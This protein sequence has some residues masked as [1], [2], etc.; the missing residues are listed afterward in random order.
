M[1]PNGY[2]QYRGRKTWLNYLLSVLVVLLAL[3]L[4]VSLAAL[5]LFPDRVRGWIGLPSAAPSPI[6][7]D[8]LSD[9]LVVE[10]AA[11]SS[12]PA[13]TPSPAASM[14]PRR[15]AP[16]GLVSVSAE[17]LLDGSARSSLKSS[18]G[19]VLS[20]KTAAGQWLEEAFSAANAE[21]P[22]VAAYLS[23]FA[24][25]AAAASHPDWALK[26]AAGDAYAD[27]RGISWLD[28]ANADVQADLIDRCKTLAGQGFDEI[29]LG[30]CAYPS[31]DLARSSELTTFC[32]ALKSALDEL[33]YEGRLSIVS[34]KDVFEASADAVTGQTLSAV[35]ECFERVYLSGA[36]RWK[37]GTNVYRLLQNAGFEGTAGDIVTLVS[38]P[39]SASYAWA[40]L[41]EN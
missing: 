17:K 4:V 7:S 40:V 28:P 33:G 34:T 21:A 1:K 41:E 22:Y 5:L 11:P 8:E 38:R 29:I 15:S 31:S 12:T 35:A 10:S 20:V 16:L 25:D 37:S 19:L 30:N 14:S 24:D 9:I 32:R 2:S 23:C 6:P 36:I 18:Q 26:T 13:P 39:I 3:A 27:E